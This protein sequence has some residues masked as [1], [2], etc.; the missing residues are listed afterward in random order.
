MKKMFLIGA[1]VAAFTFVGCSSNDKDVS[2]SET[3][4]SC[5]AKA[6][7]CGECTEGASPAVVGEKKSCDGSASPGVVGENKPCEGKASQ[8]P[9]SGAKN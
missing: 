4:E 8:C 3:S 6:K 2:M 7:A 9:F 5:C 1:A